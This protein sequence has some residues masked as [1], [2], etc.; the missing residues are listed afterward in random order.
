MSTCAENEN[1]VN[2]SAINLYSNTPSP[3]PNSTTSSQ[4]SNNCIITEYEFKTEADQEMVQALFNDLTYRVINSSSPLIDIMDLSPEQIAPYLE[5]VPRCS[6]HNHDVDDLTITRIG[7]EKHT[8]III[9][10]PDE[11]QIKLF[12]LFAHDVYRGFVYHYGYLI[13]VTLT[14]QD[15]TTFVPT[16]ALTLNQTAPSTFPASVYVSKLIDVMRGTVMQYARYVPENCTPQDSYQYM[17][18]QSTLSPPAPMSGKRALHSRETVEEYEVY[19]KGDATPGRMKYVSS[20]NILKYANC[21]NLANSKVNRMSVPYNVM[22]PDLTIEW[23]KP[24]P[25]MII[26]HENEVDGYVYTPV[27]MLCSMLL[28]PTKEKCV[29]AAQYY[30]IEKL[31]ENILPVIYYDYDLTTGVLSLSSEYEPI[32]VYNAFD[33]M[34]MYR[35]LLPNFIELLAQRT[36]EVVSNQRYNTVPELTISHIIPLSKLDI[37]MSYLGRTLA[38]HL[39]EST[40][41]RMINVAHRKVNVQYQLFY[42]GIPP[43]VRCSILARSGTRTMTNSYSC[44]CDNY[45]EMGYFEGRSSIMFYG[46]QVIT[47]CGVITSINNP[48]LHWHTCLSVL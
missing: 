1:T 31:P 44:G 19:H 28:S 4:C 36:A 20:D 39:T 47:P 9:I 22:A 38:S 32:N 14:Y 5:Y 34:F 17:S 13:E 23:R 2:V 21:V 26:H 15:I 6:I 25:L 16:E 27:S 24:V 35:E 10:N 7:F 45:S 29:I 43:H 18:V 48:C 41:I 40:F 12:K 33:V 8:N 3:P 42:F 30:Y 37:V 11:Q 46:S